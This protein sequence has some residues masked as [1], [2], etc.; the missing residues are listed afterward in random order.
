[1]DTPSR[2]EALKSSYNSLVE[3]LRDLMR[4][5]AEN[6]GK[7]VTARINGEEYTAACPRAMTREA[8][9]AY[10]NVILE[11]IEDTIEK[12]KPNHHA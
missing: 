12:E 1:M 9:E 8:E 5:S 4:E 11:H 3:A 6:G 2:G 10:W 7:P